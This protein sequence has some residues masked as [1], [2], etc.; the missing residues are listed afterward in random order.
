MHTLDSA[1]ELRRPRH[2]RHTVTLILVLVVILQMADQLMEAP[3]TRIFESIYCY[4]YYEVHDPSK[5]L[6]PRAT[7]GPGAVGGVKEELCKVAEVQSA[8]AAL[9]GNQLFWTGIPCE[10]FCLCSSKCFFWS[11][12]D[13]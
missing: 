1:T 12:A 7:I 13:A 4:E 11:I 6:M 2:L 8:V 3:T 10:C 5:L 9:E